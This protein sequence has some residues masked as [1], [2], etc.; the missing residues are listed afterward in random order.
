MKSHKIVDGDTMI[1][2][3]N[4][5]DKRAKTASHANGVGFGKRAVISTNLLSTTS[6]GSPHLVAH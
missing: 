4:I 1:K 5:A 3:G 2:E 6:W